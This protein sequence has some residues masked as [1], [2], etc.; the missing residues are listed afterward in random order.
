MFLTKAKKTSCSALLLASALFLGA[1]ASAQ[2]ALSLP[3]GSQPLAQRDTA[4]GR[5]QLPLGPYQSG[6]VPSRSVEGRIQRHTWRLNGESTSLQIL[7]PLRSQL[8]ADGYEITFQCEDRLCGGFDFRFGIEV[9]PAPDMVVSIGDYQF[10]TA[11]KD[12]V[13]RTVLVSR[14]GSASYVQIVT[15]LSGAEDL[16]APLVTESP[17]DPVQPE[18]ILADDISKK[19]LE[20]A[21][22]TL[23][24]AVLP[25]VDFQSGSAD[26]AQ[27]QMPSVAAL[28]DFMQRLPSARVLIVGHTDTDG[29]L[30]ANL[31][32]SQRRA[33]AVKQILISDYE[34]APE[35]LSVA[36]AGY[37]SPIASNTT[38]AGR[39]MNRRVEAVLLPQQVPD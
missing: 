14:A 7:S 35:R 2:R 27:K 32:L 17:V 5:Y 26:L 23:G 20:T 37:L 31:T 15:V 36:G 11:E 13:V 12:D 30:E 25:G 39:E 3:P 9:I 24:R 4:L 21:F 19:T 16:V 38:A 10:L 1:E 33:A 34:I 18:V 29:A 6:A 8:K 22:E 28:A